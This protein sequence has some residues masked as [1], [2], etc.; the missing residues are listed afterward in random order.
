MDPSTLGGQIGYIQFVTLPRNLFIAY[1]FFLLAFE[2]F[3][4]VYCYTEAGVT[5]LHSRDQIISSALL[6][7]QPTVYGGH[8]GMPS[9][10]GTLLPCATCNSNQLDCTPHPPPPTP[11]IHL[12]PTCVDIKL[13]VRLIFAAVAMPWGAQCDLYTSKGHQVT[14]H[15][16]SQN[17]WHTLGGGGGVEG[18]DAIKSFWICCFLY[19]IGI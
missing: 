19:S 10:A 16:Y 3:E 15:C 2:V 17:R 18:S 8:A 11:H 14:D 1:L 4:M 5:G 13:L 7:T 6:I 12:A 9:Q